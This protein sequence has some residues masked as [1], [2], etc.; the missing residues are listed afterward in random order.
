MKL[1][2]IFVGVFANGELIKQIG[3]SIILPENKSQRTALIVTVDTLTGLL[4]SQY[5]TINSEYIAYDYR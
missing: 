1:T 5:K 2:S 3:S 4:D